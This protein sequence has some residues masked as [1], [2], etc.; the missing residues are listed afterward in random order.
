MWE[1]LGF[2]R[3]AKYLHESS[4][5]VVD[6]YEG[7]LPSD[8][9]ELQ[10][11]KGI[12]PYTAG[13]IA[14]IAFGR[15][16]PLVDGNVRRVLGRLF[17]LKGD[18][19]TSGVE[20][21]FWE[22]AEKLIEGEHPGD[23]NQALMELGAMIC[24][25]NSP[26]CMLCPVR[27]HCR[28]FEEGAVEDY[29][30]SSKRAKQKPV[31]VATSVVRRRDSEEF[32][33]IRRDHSEL[34]SGLWEFPAVEGDYETGEVSGAIDKFLKEHLDSDFSVIDRDYL[35]S[36]L[37]HFSHLRMTLLIEKRLLDIDAYDC[38]KSFETAH[39]RAARWVDRSELEDVAMS[40]AMRKVQ[41]AFEDERSET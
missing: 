5:K 39:G 18:P 37:H 20:D 1:G 12:G 24:T 11:L 36:R 31:T 16:A 35:G 17:A 23:F 27:D 13:A 25:P 33:V 22:K 3:R 15:E 38:H 14:S 41:R 8:A 6:E 28:A 4:R 19:D 2:Y 29:P 34:L 7:Q 32:L 10:N 9:D 26:S 21:V 40:M 30:V